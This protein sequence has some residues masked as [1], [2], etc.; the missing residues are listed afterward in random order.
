MFVTDTTISPVDLARQAEERGF[1]SLYL[2]EHTHIP[3][4]RRTPAPT[5]EPLAQE[6]RR[7]MDPF[8]SLAAAASVT[9]RIRLGTGICLV[10]QRDYLVT[11][12]A[13]ATLDVLSDGRFVFGVGYGWNA[14]EMASHDLDPTRR[15]QIL[16]E[17]VLA[18]KRLWSDDVASFQGK[19]VHLAP[20]WA[21][22]KPTQKPYPPIMLGGAPGPTLFKHIAEFADGWL[23]IGGA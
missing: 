23:P 21:W 20:S 1:S 4:S 16:R 17:K 18:M 19:H 12:K 11:A 13:V 3:T 8:V 15:R 9:S 10:A 22:P 7:T 14:D 5:G 2:P 6:Y